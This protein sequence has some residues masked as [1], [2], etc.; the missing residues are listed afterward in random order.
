MQYYSFPTITHVDDLKIALDGR[1]EIKIMDRG[2]YDVID[3]LYVLP[4]TFPTIP[5]TPGTPE[6]NLAVLRRECRGLLFNKDGSLL[7]RRLHKF[8]NMG[9]R[10]ETLPGNISFQRP[11]HIL[12]KEDGSMVS[13][14]MDPQEHIKWVFEQAKGYTQRVFWGTMMG[15]TD[16]AQGCETYIS[17]ANYDYEGFARDCISNGWTPI[18]EWCSPDARIVLKHERARLVLLAIRHNQTGVYK[19][20]E[21]VCEWSDR[22]G[23]PVVESLGCVTDDPATF[24]NRV[25]G[26]T[27]IEGYV[28]QFNN[29]HAMKLKTSWYLRFHKAKEN[30]VFEKDVW[31]LILE[32]DVDDVMPVLMDHDRDRLEVFQVEFEQAMHDAAAQLEAEVRNMKL[33]VGGARGA[34]AELVKNN[35]NLPGSLKGMAFKLFSYGYGEKEHTPMS[36]IRQFAAN[37]VGTASK[38]EEARKIIGVN[39]W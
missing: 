33:K 8:F 5:E 13:P 17:Q 6:W 20:Y 22:Y 29:G 18:F 14:Y 30:L 34:Y 16:V 10:E 2:D 7:S 38:I 26:E 39:P 12:N 19:T 31:N 1:E 37:S 15:W 32:G 25:H 4:D 24:M 27:N 28:V 3:Y 21:E 9:E 36:L 23:I 11:H 35:E